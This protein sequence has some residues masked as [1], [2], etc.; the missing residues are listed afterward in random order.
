VAEV[1][2]DERESLCKC[3]R[4][5]D[6]ADPWDAV[7]LFLFGFLSGICATALLFG[8]MGWFT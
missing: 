5:Y 6:A 1:V 3:R 8:A 7:M 2:R 4:R